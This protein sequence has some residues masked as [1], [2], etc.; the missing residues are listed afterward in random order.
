MSYS[1]H[2]SL[3]L[4]Q[5]MKSFITNVLKFRACLKT[6]TKRVSD[7]MHSLVISPFSR[8]QLKYLPS[9][10]TWFLDGRTS[11]LVSIDDDCGDDC[12]GETDGENKCVSSVPSK[13]GIHG[14]DFDALVKECK[15]LRNKL[16]DSESKLKSAQLRISSVEYDYKM[17]QFYVGFTLYKELKAWFDTSN[18]RPMKIS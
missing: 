9:H 14:E 15:L 6:K 12:S 4:D 3:P 18:S 7:T 13:T 16:L 5:P 17:I 11:I 10:S 1:S 8:D 2:S